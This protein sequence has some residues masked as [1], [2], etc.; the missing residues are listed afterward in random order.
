MLSLDRFA[1]FLY[2]RLRDV[3]VQRGGVRQVPQP[4]EN[5]N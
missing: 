5:L 2:D 3:N 4:E 1:A